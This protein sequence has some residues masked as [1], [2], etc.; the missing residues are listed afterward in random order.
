MSITKEQFIAIVTRLASY[1]VMYAVGR[2]WIPVNM[3]GETVALLVGGADL[4]YAWI[5]NSRLGKVRATERM[6]EVAA[7]VMNAKGSYLA[8]SARTGPKVVNGEAAKKIME[9]VE[10]VRKDP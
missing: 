1:G 10:V 8:D 9:V 5:K 6:S 2:G 3:Q 4:A 7:I